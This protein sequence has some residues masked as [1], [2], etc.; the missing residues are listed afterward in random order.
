MNDPLVE[1]L[2]AALA[3][4]RGL[5]ALALG[6]SRARGTAGPAADYDFGLY[7]EADEPLRVEDLRAAIAPLVDDSAKLTLTEIGGWG[8]WI[9]GGGW[10]SISGRKVDLLY[11]DLNRVR[12]VVADC[13]AGRV[14]MHYQPG[15]PHGFCSAIWMGE[16]ALCLPLRDEAGAIAALIA[17]ASPYPDALRQAL[18]ARFH[19]EA[20]FSIDNAETA[21][22][23]GDETHVAGCAYRALCCLA[24]VLFAL[25]RRYLINEKGALA[26]AAGFPVTIETGNAARMW[27]AV[28]AGDLEAGLRIL[29][30]M[31][32]ELDGIV[33]AG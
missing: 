7:Y 18:I 3:P 14:E 29:K 31:A 28:G 32:G 20:R 24:Q 21:L 9:N 10:L 1:R 11:R 33:A 23:R 16:A 17:R 13:A 2:S 26:E 19:G 25:N 27:A 8:P 4:V 22:P 6:G 30:G 15:H 5:A 12:A